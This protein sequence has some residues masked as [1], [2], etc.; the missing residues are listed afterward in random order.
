MN[1]ADGTERGTGS[2]AY[3]YADETGSLVRPYT[4]TRGRTRPVHQHAFDLMSVVALVPEGQPQ[5]ALDHA[6]T[7]LLE[8]VSD[9]PRPVA[10]LAA[11]A[12]LPV[13]ALRVLLGD[14]LDAG[15][16][17]I[18]PARAAAGQPDPELLREVIDRLRGL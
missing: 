2:D 12:D 8:L 4:V 6:R 15:L 13:G 5:T 7:S 10:E 9:A 18:A 3:W 1:P 16:V 14:L 17:T 11:D